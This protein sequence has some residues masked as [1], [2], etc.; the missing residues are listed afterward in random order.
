MVCMPPRQNP[1]NSLKSRLVLAD[2]LSFVFLL[3][4]QRLTIRQFANPVWV[5][6]LITLFFRIMKHT[7]LTWS[8]HEPPSRTNRTSQTC[9]TP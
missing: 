1:P 6:C 4:N 5:I 2:S 9:P 8:H 7:H 3:V